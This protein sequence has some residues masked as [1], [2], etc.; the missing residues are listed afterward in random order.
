MA[1][2][3]G[4]SIVLTGASSGIGRALALALAAQRP[5]LVLAARDA[6]RL[7]EVAGECRRLGAEAL[8]VPTDVSAEEACKRLVALA[9]DAFGGIDVLVNNAGIT[10][11]ARMDELADPAIYER[12]MRVN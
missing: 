9:A 7:E 1:A 6:A 3:A 8:V 12:L 4:K 10:M 2:Y 11:M 5:R